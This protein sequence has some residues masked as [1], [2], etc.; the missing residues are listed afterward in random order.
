MVTILKR[1]VYQKIFL[2]KAK[3][4]QNLNFFLVLGY[5]F[6]ASSYF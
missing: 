2:N 4:I 6:V 3:N 5:N 1:V